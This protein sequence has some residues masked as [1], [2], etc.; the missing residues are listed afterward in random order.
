MEVMR[1]GLIDR[2]WGVTL[3]SL[4]RAGAT[5]QLVLQTDDGKKYSIAFSAGAIVGASSPLAA[6]SIARIALTTQ[7]VSSSQV[8]EIARKV[9][10]FPDRDEVALLNDLAKLSPEQIER[11]RRRMILQRAARSFA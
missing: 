7:L 10:A 6:D 8:Q 2:P 4:A 9:A 11:L 5:G 1:G 3:G